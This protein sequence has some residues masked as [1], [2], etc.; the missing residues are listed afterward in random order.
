MKYAI[1]MLNYCVSELVERCVS[2]FKNCS[3]QEGDT[4]SFFIV[5]NHSPN[6]DGEKLKSIFKNSPNVEVLITDKN[7]GFAKGNNF[8]LSHFDKKQFD[9]IIEAN[10]NTIMVDSMLFQ[11]IEDSYLH[12]KFAIMGPDI[13]YPSLKIHQNPLNTIVPTVD[14]YERYLRKTRMKIHIVKVFGYLGLYWLLSI[15]IDKRKR[16]DQI[17]K[18]EPLTSVILSGSFLV[19]S[20]LFF[21]RFQYLFYPDTFLYF[22]EHF[23]SLLCE[24]KNLVT[25][26]NPDIIVV[27]EEKAS[28]KKVNKSKFRSELFYLTNAEKS[29]LILLNF[30]QTLNFKNKI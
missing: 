29:L 4:I 8:A 18:K 9:F 22:E 2:S 27:H 28:V 30:Y 19:F 16:K 20:P 17:K 25:L 11:K 5:D 23:L 1:V 13:F 26:Y 7:L 21:N 6:G 24:D 14:Y 15:I 3:M 12:Y 10:P